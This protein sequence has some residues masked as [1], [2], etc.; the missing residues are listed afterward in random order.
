M[1]RMYRIDTK[2]LEEQR[3]YFGEYSETKGS[4]IDVL[5]SI[6]RDSK[7]LSTPESRLRD[8]IIESLATYEAIIKTAHNRSFFNHTNEYTPE[9]EQ[10]RDSFIELYALYVASMVAKKR[11]DEEFPEEGEQPIDG[12]VVLQNF[13]FE[14]F[15]SNISGR[16]IPEGLKDLNLEATLP[17]GAK[18]LLNWYTSKI[19]ALVNNGITLGTIVSATKRFYSCL[20]EAALERMRM[21]RYSSFYIQARNLNIQTD[22][23]ILQGLEGC[24]KKDEKTSQR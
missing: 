3:R 18:Y 19:K 11:L 2:E 1:P 22:G 8:C 10:L 14:R 24:L 13:N 20:G 6:N 12:S 16:S 23:L 15:H 21:E 7:V 5:N 9:R 17:S 4:L